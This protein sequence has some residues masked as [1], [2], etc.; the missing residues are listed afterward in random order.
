M[1]KILVVDDDP[2]ARRILVLLLESTGEVFEASSGAEALRLI[3]AERPRLML[4]DMSMPGLSGLDVLKAAQG[5]DAAM[6]ILMLTC[7]TDM[8]LAKR[9]LELGAE[10]FITKPFDCEHLKEKVKRC[11]EVSSGD[12][13]KDV[14]LPWRTVSG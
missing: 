11:L 13:K 12:V 3:A 9:A 6:T 1:G 14:G 7:A 2:A 5:G 10:E 8:E 4:L